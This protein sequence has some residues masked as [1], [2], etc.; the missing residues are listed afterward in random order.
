M[1]HGGSMKEYTNPG[2]NKFG[3]I[4]TFGRPGDSM[5]PKNTHAP[6]KTISYNANGTGR[7][8]YIHVTSGG[9]HF[10]HPKNHPSNFYV[11]SLRNW[12]KEG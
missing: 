12:T 10:D 1:S 9:N 5:S 6:A 2:V 3:A 8:S 7:D 11:N 4:P